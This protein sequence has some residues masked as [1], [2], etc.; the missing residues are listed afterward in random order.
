M[1]QHWQFA[2]PVCVL[3]EFFYCRSYSSLSSVTSY[4]SLT[5]GFLLHP[6]RDDDFAA[7]N[8]RDW[9]RFRNCTHHMCVSS[10]DAMFSMQVIKL[11]REYRLYTALAY[12]FPRALLDHVAP[13]AEL[14][15]ATAA[16]ARHSQGQPQEVSWSPSKKLGFK[17]LVYLRTCF[18]GLTFPP[19]DLQYLLDAF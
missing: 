2:G 10:D 16:A 15:M 8:G 11:C 14:T 1:I 5:R 7:A 18:A 6:T 3:Y 9:R 17:L 4:T 13:V 19:G 12:L